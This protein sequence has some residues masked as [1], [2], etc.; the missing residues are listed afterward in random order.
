MTTLQDGALGADR[1]AQIERVLARYP[2][3]PE[4][5]LAD[6]IHW[7]RKE[8]TALDVAMLASNPDVAEPYRQFRGDHLDRLTGNDYVRGLVFA[9]IVAAIVLIIVWRAL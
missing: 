4:D 1:R 9:A 8:A 6:V 5:Q 3:L 2:Q 7:F